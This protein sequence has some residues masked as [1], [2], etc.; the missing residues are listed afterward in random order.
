MI[1]SISRRHF[2]RGSGA[3]IALPAIESIGFKPF[4]TAAAKKTT[5][6]PKRLIFMSM[7]FGVTNDSWYPSKADNGTGY[8]LSEGLAP[9]KTHQKNFTLVQ[10]CQNKL[11]REAHWGSTMWLTGANRYGIPGQSFSNT[12]SADQVAAAQFGKHTRFSSIQLTKRK[13]QILF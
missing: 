9:L 2:L 12:I 1:S 4:A 13:Y 6:P 3:V 7:G 10:G 5:K 11:L 8:K